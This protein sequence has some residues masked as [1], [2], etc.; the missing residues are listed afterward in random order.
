MGNLTDHFASSGG[1]NNILE[2]IIFHPKGQT[3]TTIKGDF[4]AGNIT[5]HQDFTT[6]TMTL[7]TGSEIPYIPPD[8]TTSVYLKYEFA[9]RKNGDDGTQLGSVAFEL[10][11]SAVGW[12]D[13]WDS[14]N[15]WFHNQTTYE[16]NRRSIE[17][18]ISINGTEDIE[19]GS[20]SS[21]DSERIIR[22][23][24]A[25]YSASYSYRMHRLDYWRNAG[26]DSFVRPTMTIIAMK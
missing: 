8:G 14:R 12:T 21:W 20:L 25:T 13:I 11:T 9:C 6:S 17:C 4:T 16:V 22:V 18:I 7:V 5:T 24:A 19:Q 15:Q 2:E 23:R 26:T 3:I 10:G 1:G